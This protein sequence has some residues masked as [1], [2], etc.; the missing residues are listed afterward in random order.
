MTVWLIGNTLVFIYI[1]T[2]HLVWLVLMVGK[3]S[4]YVTSHAGKLSVA[5]H[6]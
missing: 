3:P 5:I 1:V 6:L 4:L 2:L